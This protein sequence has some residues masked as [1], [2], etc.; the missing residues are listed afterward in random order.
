MTALHEHIAALVAAETASF[1]G[2]DAPAL[3]GRHT[4]YAD[5]NAEGHDL[6]CRADGAAYTARVA[7]T[8]GQFQLSREAGEFVIFSEQ[9]SV[10]GFALT[11]FNTVAG[12]L[13]ILCASN[14]ATR[15]AVAVAA[16]A[17]AGISFAAS[18][19]RQRSDADESTAQDG[20]DDRSGEPAGAQVPSLWTEA[21]QWLDA[22]GRAPRTT[23]VVLAVRCTQLDAKLASVAA[24][25]ARHVPLIIVTSPSAVSDPY[26]G[27]WASKHGALVAKSLDSAVRLGAALSCIDAPTG[28][29]FCFV[30]PT[31]ELAAV[32]QDCLRPPRRADVIVASAEAEDGLVDGLTRAAQ[33]GADVLVVAAP[34]LAMSEQ[35]RV[36][37]E[38]SAWRRKN[39]SQVLI[40][41]PIGS[42][43]WSARL[44]RQAQPWRAL[45]TT[46][47]A[48]ARRACR[49]AHTWEERSTPKRASAARRPSDPPRLRAALRSLRTLT[50]APQSADS[51]FARCNAEFEV[52][53]ALGL[54]ARRGRQIAYL[55]DAQLA[56]SHIGFP[57]QI[58][59]AD[60]QVVVDV[61]MP[62]LL[63]TTIRSL[64]QHAPVQHGF[65]VCEHVDALA[66]CSVRVSEHSA[67]GPVAT[68]TGSRAVQLCIPLIGDM[69]QQPL[70]EEAETGLPA[71]QLAFCCDALAS[72]LAK[73]KTECI[74]ATVLRSRLNEC[75]IDALKIG[76]SDS[77]HEGTP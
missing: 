27:A 9:G 17:G 13:A 4:E 63:Q 66:T 12:G 10:A 30:T 57:L 5:C 20:D 8:G 25:V 70:L 42:D 11:P 26:A 23:A 39:S 22:A 60:R 56:A 14:V 65:T 44:R 28:D 47:L 3:V 41:V 2:E 77:E 34:E 18:P 37:A 64:A 49:A 55:E 68:V 62:D 16:G 58:I 54:S 51:Y 7:A 50:G 48:A 75:I 38:V 40:V 1:C 45:V 76:F 35:S 46:D 73:G 32:W 19:N 72:A 61:A 33:R 67:I 36:V 21:A 74:E 15:Y 59:S 69:Q 24:L 53:S 6:V 71:E 52:I 31:E 43:R 29:A